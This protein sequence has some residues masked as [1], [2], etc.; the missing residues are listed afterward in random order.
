MS[1][2]KTC[3]KKHCDLCGDNEGGSDG[4]YFCDL[5]ISDKLLEYIE[6]L[7]L[8]NFFNKAYDNWMLEMQSEIVLGQ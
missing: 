3:D 2:C 8:R 5:C 1:E 7:R 6:H 4:I